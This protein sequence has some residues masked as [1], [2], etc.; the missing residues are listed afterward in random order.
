MFIEDI[1][2]A[3]DISGESG[4]GLVFVS[5]ETPLLDVADVLSSSNIGLVLVL[6]E[7]AKLMGVLSERDIVT[8]IAKN[9]AAALQTPAQDAMTRNA[10]TCAPRDNPKDVINTMSEGRFR[11]MPIID[12]GRLTGLVSSSDILKYLSDKMSPDE[13][14][15]IWTK[16][17]WI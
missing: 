15:R 12:Q 17:L 9:G 5:P 4:N 7:A 6:D 10:R 11:H 14:F 13:Q 16:S 3:A 1:V 2:K 8:A